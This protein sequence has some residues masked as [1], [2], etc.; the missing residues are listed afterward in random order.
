[1]LKI[2]SWFRLHCVLVGAAG[3]ELGAV[4]CEKIAATEAGGIKRVKWF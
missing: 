1:M 2:K 3:L 4:I